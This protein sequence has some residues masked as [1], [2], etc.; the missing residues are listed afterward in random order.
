MTVARQPRIEYPGAV[1]YLAS[2]GDG[3]DAIFK[4]AADRA[5]FLETLAQACQ[6]TGWEVLAYRLLPQRLLLVVRTPQPNLAAGMKWLL[7]AYTLRFNRRHGVVGHLFAG[8]YRSLLVEP[9]APFLPAVCEFTHLAPGWA[10][11]ARLNLSE[12]PWSSF[13]A[14]LRPPAERPAWLNCAPLLDCLGCEDT[15][16]GR[17]QFA[18]ILEAARVG[19][20]NPLW[21]QVRRGWRLGGPDFRREVMQRLVGAG[22]SSAAPGRELARERAEE[23]VREELA[24]LGW[25][26][27][28][29]AR[30]PKGDPEKVRIARRVRAETTAS[31]R[32]VGR[33]LHM[34][35]WT[36]AANALYRQDLGPTEPK[37]AR[38]R[39]ATTAKTPP[40]AIEELPV[41]CL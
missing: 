37:R 36:S 31:L 22:P 32:W 18:Q 23:I 1:Y 26:E 38:P 7:G 24:A 34:G 28:D 33:R 19:P 11:R 20:A 9:T 35:A 8:R 14:Y 25:S 12:L 6:K 5:L 30:R 21:A 16:A 40:P 39:R 3:G 17:A 27:T 4:D 15:P 10:D 41:H 13:P 2:Q 29:L